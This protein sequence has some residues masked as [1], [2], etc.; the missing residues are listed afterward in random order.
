M[1]ITLI[2]LNYNLFLPPISGNVKSIV[3]SNLPLK[4]ILILIII[5]V[6]IIK[7]GRIKAGSNKSGIFVAKIS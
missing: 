3:L 1:F 2:L 6:N 7:T 5:V 4:L